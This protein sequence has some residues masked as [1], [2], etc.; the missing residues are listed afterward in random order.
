[1]V[2]QIRHVIDTARLPKRGPALVFGAAE[3]AAFAGVDQPTLLAGLFELDCS[4]VDSR[5][6]VDLAAGR[7]VLRTNLPVPVKDLVAASAGRVM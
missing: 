1:M 3:W 2:D 7:D 5:R 4:E 6:T